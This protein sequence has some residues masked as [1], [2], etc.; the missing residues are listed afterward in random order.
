MD[1][2]SAAPVL[3]MIG[4]LDPQKGFDLLAEAAPA[5]V[6]LGFRLAVLGSG[7]ADHVQP[8]RT[9]AAARPDRVALLERF[10]RDL[11]RR[12]YAGSDGFL[13][14]SR[15]EP[16]G[17]GQMIALRYGTPPIVRATGGLK[18]TVIDADAHPRTGTGF[19]F[20]DASAEALTGACR[21]FGAWHTNGGAR[22]ERLLDRG[23]AVDFDWRRTS[24]PAYLAA[25]RRAIDRRAIDRRAIDRRAPAPSGER[26]TGRA[27]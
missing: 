12:L 24:A 22:W 6:E 15:F 23:M 4:R 26:R 11:A 14:P 7:T 1:P 9:L 25:Y 13:M 21:R 5:L 20:E 27:R 2:S 3:S 18:D 17:T 10:D 16:C 8:L 19:L